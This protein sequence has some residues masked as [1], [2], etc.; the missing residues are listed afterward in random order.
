MS[1]KIDKLFAALKGCSF[2]GLDTVTEVK[3]TKNMPGS[4]RGKNAIPNPHHGRITKR[5]TGASI[6]VFGNTKSNG[7]ENMV[8]RRL[9]A[10]GKNPDD[11]VLSARVWGERLKGTPMV[12]KAEKDGSVSY[13]LEAIFM[14]P[15]KTEYFIDGTTPIDKED[16][17][18]MSQSK[19][20][21]AAQG[22]LENYVQIR[23]FKLDSIT[24]IRTD[25]L[26][27]IGPFTF[28]E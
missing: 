10:E 14:A 11:F 19:P 2:A 3:V 18:G 16:V 4:P 15:G 13:Y 9:E 5:M 24:Q 12:K 26:T 6:M 17:I 8:K 20:N 28:T 27:T 25:G 21:D 22:G 7:Y 1:T 23:T